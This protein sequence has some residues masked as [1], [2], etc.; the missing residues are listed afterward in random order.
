MYMCVCIC[1]NTHTY[2]CIYT[3]I[4]THMHVVYI[5]NM[6]EIYI[7]VSIK[8]VCVHICVYVHVCVYKTLKETNQD[9]NHGNL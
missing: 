1:M 2:T 5:G 3:H 9:I 4:H 7:H 8:Y 6:C